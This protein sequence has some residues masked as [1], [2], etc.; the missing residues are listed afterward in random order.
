MRLPFDKK[1]NFAHM[2]KN[3]LFISLIAILGSFSAC[4]EY[5]K[6]LKSTDNEAK[7][8]KSMELYEKKDYNR[9]LQ[10]FDLLQSAYRGSKR[11]EE[12]SYK[13]AYCYYY[14]EDYDV[15]AYYFKRFATN[16]PFS[17]EAEEMLYMDA[18]CN[19]LDS[20][21]SSL[22]QSNT[23]AAIAEF[24]YFIDSYPQ[25]DRVDTANMYIDKLRDKL[26]E[27]EYNICKMYYKMGDY[28]AAITSFENLLKDY[29]ETRHR[30]EIL[31]DMV[32]TYYDYAENSVVEKKRERYEASIDKYNTLLYLYPESQYLKELEPIQAKAKNKLINN[33]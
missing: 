5:S 11:G 9:A 31:H 20:P 17:K 33:K 22:D 26:Q 30:E 3:I 21:N 24:Q 13:T 6:L 27:K 2:R 12:I 10:L 1:C 18:Y 4:T 14:L 23:R 32:I 25:S 15:A 29:P 16:F 8:A 7:Y 28:M 19:Y